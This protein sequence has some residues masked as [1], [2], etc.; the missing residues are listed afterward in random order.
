MVR[1]RE[2]P[3]GLTGSNRNYFVDCTVH[4]TEEER[5]IIK[6]R[7]LYDQSIAARASTPLP[8]GLS[9]FGT[10]VMRL[11]GRFMMIGGLS[12][13]LIVEGLAGARSNFGAPI[14]FIGIGLELY[15]WVRT[16]KED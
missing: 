14:L 3:A 4:F 9:F 11:I 7:G 1:H 13:G 8:S 15:G 2:T 10:N 6:A 12:Y 16:H 5:G